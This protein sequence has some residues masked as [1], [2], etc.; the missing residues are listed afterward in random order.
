MQITDID[1]KRYVVNIRHAKDDKDKIVPLSDKILTLLR[2]YFKQC[3]PEKWLFEGQIAG[4]QC[5]ET[6]SNKVLQN[7]KRKT[8]IINAL[9]TS[10]IK[11]LLCDAF[12]G[13]RNRYPVYLGFAWAQA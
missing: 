11:T 4:T 8:G 3:K 10:S 7:A 2:E 12:A 6:S 1:L 13:S 5:T 9:H